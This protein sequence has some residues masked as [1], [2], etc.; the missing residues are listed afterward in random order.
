MNLNINIRGDRG[1]WMVVVLLSLVSLLVVYSS[2]VTLAD[3]H[4]GGNTLH[5]LFRH[6][7]FLAV[8]LFIMHQISRIK[9]KY[10]SKFSL[11]AIYTAI[12]LLLYTLIGGSQINEAARWIKI[13]I[14]N[15]TFQTSD[16]AKLSLIMYVARTLAVNQFERD[17]FRKIFIPVMLPTL[18]VCGL[19]FPANLSTAALLFIS[20]ITLMFIGRMS[21][22]FIGSTLG[23]I[24]IGVLMMFLI[25]KSYPDVMPRRFSTWIN[26]I[27]N[28]SNSNNKQQELKGNYQA[29][30]SKIA[31]ARGRIF[32]Q[33]PGKSVQ[34]NVLPHPYSDF[35]YAIVIEEYGL[36]GGIFVLGLYLFFLFRCLKIFVKAQ[37]LFGKLLVAGICF[38]LVFQAL[39]NMAVAC[40]LMP[41]TG[42]PLPLI[43]MGGTSI[44]FTCLSIG[45]ILSVSASYQKPTKIA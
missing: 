42:Q 3:K 16:L 4:H 23:A 40:N 35:I 20:S 9:F 11:V 31:I 7:V 30:N 45:I 38:T 17:D 2:I 12:P 14:I 6:G 15:Q 1:I 43:S 24:F 26:R 28:F 41:V 36:L 32:G 10:F 27:E 37:S 5:Y 22:L 19:I 25:G 39:I 33:G 29:L 44:W 8:G 13:P 34:R 21:F 18:L